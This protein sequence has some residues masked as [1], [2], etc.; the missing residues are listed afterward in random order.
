[1]SHLPDNSS[2]ETRLPQ[3]DAVRFAAAVGVML[4]HYVSCF[5]T[6]T[7]ATSGVV[8]ALSHV[9]RYGYLGVDLFFMTSG[10]VILWSSIN[11]DATGF[12]ISRI[13]RLYPAFWL[14]L[15]LVT[16]LLL[17][18]GRSVPEAS[19]VEI[20]ARTLLANVTMM[21]ALFNSPPIEG[22][23]WT[24]EIEI[25][26]YALIFM[27]LLLRQM[28]YVEAWLSVWLAV[29]VLGLFVELPWVVKYFAL[30]PYGPFFIAGCLFYLIRTR[31]L[32]LH[33]MAGLAVA[34]AACVYV[35]IGQR[36]EFLTADAIS[37]VVVPGL[38]ALFF[39]LFA[40]LALRRPV[41]PGEWPHARALGDLT[42][43]LYLT[44]ATMGLIAYHLLRPVLGVVPT[45]LAITALALIVAWLVTR[46]VDV[47]ARKPFVRL[48]S[49]GAAAVGLHR[50][51]TES[52]VRNT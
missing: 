15:I 7:D 21:P 30:Q 39:G 27:L 10:F 4:Y 34:G 31:G 19:N 14:S 28:R 36:G 44:H 43:S 25:R 13:S 35:S 6:G 51:G 50:G 29:A 46:T 37:S 8:G 45:I 3:L 47:P 9:T 38:I 41:A 52:P 33:R 23:Y 40:A 2:K 42:Y 5:P 1:V 18:L 32:N 11:R 16:L 17:T 22:V 20:S 48:L 49:R 12:T 24:L 26:F